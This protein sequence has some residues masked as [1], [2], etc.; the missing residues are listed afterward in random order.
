VAWLAPHRLG[1]DSLHSAHFHFNNEKENHQTMPAATIKPEIAPRAGRTAE[2]GAAG[3]ATVRRGRGKAK[4]PSAGQP[5]FTA[6]VRFQPK[7]AIIVATKQEEIGSSVP[8]ANLFDGMTSFQE[9][10]GE[11][12][13]KADRLL[14]FAP[15]KSRSDAGSF[16]EHFL[17]HVAYT[18]KQLPKGVK[19]GVGFD[20]KSSYDPAEDK[21]GEYFL[22]LWIDC[23]WDYSLY[24]IELCHAWEDLQGN[25]RKVEARKLLARAMA[26]LEYKVGVWSWDDINFGMGIEQLEEEIHALKH[27]GPDFD[28]HVEYTEWCDDLAEAQKEL[29]TYKTG[30]A[31]QARKEISSWRSD[32]ITP[33]KLLLLA[34]GFTD[35]PFLQKAVA[36]ICTIAE[37]RINLSD[38]DNA[39]LLAKMELPPEEADWDDERVE[40]VALASTVI[41]LWKEDD[42]MSKIHLDTTEAMGQEYGAVEPSCVIPIYRHTKEIDFPAFLER[43]D[44]PRKIQKFTK[45]LNTHFCGIDAIS[46][47]PKNL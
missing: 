37:K 12:L 11:L 13:Y 26:M 42:R 10:V 6:T 17:A 24:G 28:D 20:P 46:E 45:T 30:L 23:Q 43:K 38:F 1:F 34:K 9:A 47:I 41:V 27:D 35:F 40:G 29:A 4:K 2:P 8:V 7:S 16:V 25:P 15:F 5:S 39:D 21:E 19:F 22:L 18:K 44:W 14:G 33:A 32:T 31:H 3:P 36:E